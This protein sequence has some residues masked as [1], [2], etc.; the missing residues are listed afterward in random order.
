MARFQ[1]LVQG[2]AKNVQSSLGSKKSGMTVEV[3]GWTLGIKVQA[4][5]NEDGYDYFDIY[6]NDGS[7][8][9]KAG[10]LVATFKTEEAHN[11]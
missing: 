7:F 8:R 2:Q 4:Y 9:E 10:E 1:A 6:V 5:T 11:G 3:N